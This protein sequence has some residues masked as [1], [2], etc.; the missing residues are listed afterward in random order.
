MTDTSRRNFPIPVGY[1]SIILGLAS[2]GLAWRLAADSFAFIP[3][4]IGETSLIIATVI[5]L[6]FICAYIWQWIKFTSSAIEEIEHVITGGAV[7]LVPIS[8]IFVGMAVLPYFE[9]VGKSIL[10]IGILGQISFAGYYVGGRWRGTHT[11]VAATPVMY[12]PVIPTNFLSAT[13]LGILGYTELG[14]LFLGAGLICWLMFEPAVLQ[15]LRTD[16]P[17]VEQ[18]RPVLGIQLAPAF[19]GCSAYLTLTGGEINLLVKLLIGYGLLQSIL[20]ARLL[21]WIFAYGF[22]P[23]AWA[24]SFGLGSMAK[25]G[26]YLK[27]AHPED[28]LGLLG[29]GLFILG[30]FGISLLIIGTIFLLFKGRFFA[31]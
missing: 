14:E 3:M 15:R 28:A 5:W 1:F 20:L 26:I 9:L 29:S 23:S 6:C 19:V 10:A 11:A 21:P 2:I 17:L 16:V 30:S 18:L 27:L 24:F 4:W 13:A 31:R 8:T 22:T 7:A 25:V 12:L